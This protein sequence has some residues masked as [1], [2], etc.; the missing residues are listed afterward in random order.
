MPR[1]V[2]DGEMSPELASACAAVDDVNRADPR[3]VEVD[4]APVPVELIYGQ[5][6]SAWLE[7][8]E[9]NATDTLRLA[10]RAQHIARWELRREDFPAGPVGYKRWRSELGRRHGERAQAIAV[11]TGFSQADAQRVRDLV[12]KRG[13]KV[14][15]DAQ[16]VE[17]VAC[18]VFLE[19]YFGEFAAK[20]ER[21][22]VIDIVRK[23]WKKMSERGRSAALTIDLGA[24]EAALVAAAL[25][26]AAAGE[27]H[28]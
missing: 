15:R 13:I 12:M 24:T 18:L 4:G 23:T 25:A 19:H 7:R 21:D 16:T 26:E 6:M 14:D 9:P 17:D 5:R 10:V 28:S 1:V 20:H 11:A 3:A 8:L 2:Y 22:K 27:E